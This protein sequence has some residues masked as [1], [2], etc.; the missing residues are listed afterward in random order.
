MGSGARVT[1]LAAYGV[2][3]RVTRG[4]SGEIH[5]FWDALSLRMGLGEFV[6]FAGLVTE[7]VNCPLRCGE[8]ARGRRGR[9]AR[10]SMGQIS[11]SQGNLTLWFSPEEFEELQRLTD[12]ARQR[13][14]DAEPVSSLGVPWIPEQSPIS[15]N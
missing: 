7:A 11:V 5:L 14:A 1:V 15:V 9:V 13:L 2:R 6:D 3:R 12:M 10:C 8:L 4:E